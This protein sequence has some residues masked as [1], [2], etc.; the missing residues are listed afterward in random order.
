MQP[1]KYSTDLSFE[2]FLESKNGSVNGIFKLNI[3]I[4]PL[5]QKR[6]SVHLF[7][8]AHGSRP[9]MRRWSFG[10][11]NWTTRPAPSCIAVCKTWENDTMFLPIAHA[12][13]GK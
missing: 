8:A 12:F 5:L 2:S 3:I 7:E 1:G 9:I 11:A 13:H 6:L 10:L 4:V